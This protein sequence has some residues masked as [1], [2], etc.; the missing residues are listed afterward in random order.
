[1]LQ[2]NR[3]RPWHPPA[4]AVA[5]LEDTLLGNGSFELAE[6]TGEQVIKELGRGLN[7]RK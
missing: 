6:S 5:F 2:G 7:P 1:M 4:T 3:R